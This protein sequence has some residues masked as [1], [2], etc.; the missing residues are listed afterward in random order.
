MEF[1]SP[2]RSA[3]L[4]VA[5]DSIASG[6]QSGHPSS[7]EPAAYPLP[8]TAMRASFVTL[9]QGDD[10]RG[11]I[12]SLEAYTSLVEDVAR[13]AYAAAFRDPRFPGLTAAELGGLGIHIAVLGPSQ[14]LEFAS[15]QELLE[16]L[17]PGTDGLILQDRSARGTFLPAVW[18]SLPQP[19]DFLR[20][21]KAKAGLSPDYWSDTIE[22]MRYTTEAF[23]AVASK[24]GELRVGEAG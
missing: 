5:M 17:R 11:C 2:E 9:K 7:V 1:S 3:L 15:E 23:S 10:L 20:H 19:A 8:L 18:E 4:Q 16:K 22:V 24:T 6:L 21:L 14:P 13:N 12:G